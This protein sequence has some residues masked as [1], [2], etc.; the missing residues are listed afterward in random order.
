MRTETTRSDLKV[1]TTDPSGEA[2]HFWLSPRIANCKAC[3]ADVEGVQHAPAPWQFRHEQT[4][5]IATP[6]PQSRA[7]PDIT[8][9][10]SNPSRMSNV[11]IGDPKFTKLI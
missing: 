4:G 10:T 5:L 8:G 6:A 7:D 9:N 1:K 2:D 11:L 3:A